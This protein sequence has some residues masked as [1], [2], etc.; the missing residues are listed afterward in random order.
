MAQND[1]LLGNKDKNNIAIKLK[2]ILLLCFTEMII[3]TKNVIDLQFYSNTVHK[4][5]KKINDKF[6]VEVKSFE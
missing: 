3:I 1:K 5:W 4:I 2:K 6:I